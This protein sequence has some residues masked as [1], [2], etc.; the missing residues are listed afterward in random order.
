M[1]I[2]INN[3][4]IKYTKHTHILQHKVPKKKPICHLKKSEKKFKKIDRIER[5]KCLFNKIKRK[6]EI[7]YSY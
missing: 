2:I 6:F 1:I 3:F 5:L 7:I 4:E